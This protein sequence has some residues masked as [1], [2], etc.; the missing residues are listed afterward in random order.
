MSA[1]RQADWAALVTVIK[2]LKAEP[3]LVYRYK[4]QQKCG[5]SVYVDT[6]FAGCLETRRST[7]RGCA[8]R[9]SHLIKH[10]SST[11]NVVTLSSGEAEPTG[12]LKSATEAPGLKS[13]SADLGWE[14]DLKLHA[15]S[16]PAIGICKK[17]GIGRVGHL[18]TGQVWVQ[19]RLR[20]GDFSLYKVLGAKNPADIL[21]KHVPRDTLDTLNEFA[22]LHREVERAATAPMTA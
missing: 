7:S 3:R 17:S 11:Q 20:N 16:S 14:T 12:I 4:W 5:I 1:P 15:D 8:F 13:L 6:D 2:Y 10:W 21:T 22:D 19:E 9:G 18:A